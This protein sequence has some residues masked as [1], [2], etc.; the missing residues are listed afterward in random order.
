L[1]F[2]QFFFVS[3]RGHWSF[4][5]G[6]FNFGFFGVLDSALFFP[7]QPIVQIAARSNKEEEADNAQFIIAL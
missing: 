7:P 4:S 6:E 1:I 5:G 3:A 2:D